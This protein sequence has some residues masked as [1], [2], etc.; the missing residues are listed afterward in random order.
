MT[1]H[2]TANSFATVA[3][4]LSLAVLSGNAW[5]E[6][7]P[8]PPFVLNCGPNSDEARFVLAE[9]H[10]QREISEDQIVQM[11]DVPYSRNG[12]G[13]QGG[14]GYWH[15]H[16]GCRPALGA[17][18]ETDLFSSG[19]IGPQSYSFQL[20]RGEYQIAVGMRRGRLSISRPLLPSKSSKPHVLMHPLSLWWGD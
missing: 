5:A 14:E 8:S 17:D 19:R 15:W 1:K 11:P 12:F 7:I 10:E 18:W 4:L 20:P 6:S 16:G 2:P 13:H 9:A 3:V